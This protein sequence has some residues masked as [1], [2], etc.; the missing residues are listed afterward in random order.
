MVDFIHYRPATFAEILRCVWLG[1]YSRDNPLMIYSA[2]FDASGTDKHPVITLA[3]GISSLGRWEKFVSDWDKELRFHGLPPATVF[4]MVEFVQCSGVFSIF[5]GRPSAKAA[6]FSGL[7][8]CMVKHIGK[9]FSV[10]V[11]I[12][13]YNVCDKEWCFH[14]VFGSPY[15]FAGIM[16]VK[17]SLDWLKNSPSKRK[18]PIQIFFE[19]GDVSNKVPG[20]L[21]NE[22]GALCEKH[23]SIE[24]IFRNKSMVQFQ[25]GDLL[26]WKNRTAVTNAH[27]HG[28][29]RDME[30][31]DSIQRSL[32]ELERLHAMSGVYGRQAFDKIVSGGSYYRRSEYN[33]MELKAR[34]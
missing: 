19:K 11:V 23:F 31:L 24:P 25:P 5:K 14:E 27:L 6:L 32:N 30:L 8:S 22:L 28:H 1:D 18:K 16:C 20:G 12:D 15:S 34:S 7:V 9:M 26:A 29:T 4:R 21:E 33:V 3:G 13:D 10:S 17:E 2:H